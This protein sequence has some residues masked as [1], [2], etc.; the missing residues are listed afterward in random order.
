MDL[1]RDGG[2][3]VPARLRELGQLAEQLD[4]D[5]EDL[6]AAPQPRAPPPASML[7]LDNLQV[8]VTWSPLGGMNPRCPWDAGTCSYFS[9]C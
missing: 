7:E 6:G 2:A 9:A 3:A 5:V 8:T 4:V 1:G